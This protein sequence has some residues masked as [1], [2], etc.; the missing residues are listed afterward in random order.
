MIYSAS[1]MPEVRDE[2]ARHLGQH[3][4][5]RLVNYASELAAEGEV[6]SYNETADQINYLPDL[7]GADLVRWTRTA[8][9]YLVTESMSAVVDQAA[10]SR[11]PYRL[12]HDDL[13]SNVGLLVFAGPVEVVV[14]TPVEE[15]YLQPGLPMEETIRLR[16]LLWA[17]SMTRLGP[18]V[19]V[20]PFADAADVEAM[21]WLSTYGDR[22]GVD[23]DWLR[24]KAREFMGPV[25]FLDPIPLPFYVSDAPTLNL[26]AGVAIS[27]WLLMGQRI[28]VSSTVRAGRPGAGPAGRH[29]P[30]PTV[31][32]ITL[33]RTSNPVEHDEGHV[34]AREFHVRWIV[35][36]HWRNA[37]V[38]KGRGE[39]RLTWVTEHVK[40]P[41]DAPMFGGE[42]VAVLRR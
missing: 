24:R 11:P 15:R 42:R 16:G 38:G 23:T 2:L 5:G 29:R 18:G 30:A 41:E 7:T 9:L 1:H 39:R 6:R 35:S 22:N 36:G 27:T 32:V 34:P 26:A 12:N 8:D 3:R 19:C 37:R 33:R 21:A 31:Q 14:G 25:G 17:P 4:T 40:G 10:K 28:A 20:V 13:P